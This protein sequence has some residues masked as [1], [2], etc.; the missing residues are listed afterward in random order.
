MLYILQEESFQLVDDPL[1]RR[2]PKL[3]LEGHLYR[4]AKGSEDL[5]RPALFLLLLLCSLYSCSSRF[6]L[7][8]FLQ[9][10]A[11][12]RPSVVCKVFAPQFLSPLGSCGG[13]YVRGRTMGMWS[14]MC[15]QSAIA[16]G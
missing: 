15:E 16:P 1:G 5:L 6:V 13:L 8:S 11:L 2:L 4:C 9:N 3:R 7:E 14:L 12:L 10:C